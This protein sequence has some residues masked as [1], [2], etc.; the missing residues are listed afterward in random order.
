MTLPRA[1]T[2]ASIRVTINRLT[3]FLGIAASPVNSV[4][5]ICQGALKQKDGSIT[6]V[7]NDQFPGSIVCLIGWSLWTDH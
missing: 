2:L 1:L 5:C 6:L 3:T 7:P 4:F